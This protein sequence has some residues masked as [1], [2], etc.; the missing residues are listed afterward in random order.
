MFNRVIPFLILSLALIPRAESAQPKR[1]PEQRGTVILDELAKQPES[2]TAATRRRE[3]FDPERVIRPRANAGVKLNLPPEAPVPGPAPMAAAPAYTGFMGLPDDLSAIPPDTNGAVG[4]NHVVTMLNTQVLIQ[5]RDGTYRANYPINLGGRG[6]FWSRVTTAS[7]VYDPN[8][9]YDAANDRWIASAA[10]NSNTSS[11]ALLVGVS[12]TGDPGG[13]WNMYKINV[14]TSSPGNWGDYPVLGFNGN[15][16][17]VSLNLFNIDSNTNTCCNYVNTTLYV[18]NK[19]DLYSAGQGGYVTFSDENGELIPA[20]DFDKQPNTLYFVRAF[21]ADAGGLNGSGSIEIS[22]LQ[23]PVGSETFAGGNVGEIP[24]ADPW[25]DSGANGADFL[26]QLGTPNKID[27]GDSRVQNCVLRGGTIWC[28]HTI[29]LPYSSRKGP[30]RSSVQWFQ[31]DPAKLQVLQRG[32]IDD[33]SGTY[34]YAYPTIAV[35]ANNDVLVGYNRFSAQDYP[36]AE[37]SYRL[38]TDPPSTLEPDVL[39]AKGQ[40]SYVAPGFQT[41]NNRWGDF[42]RTWTDPVDDLTFWTI[43]EYAVTP[44]HGTTGQFGTWWAEVTAPSVVQ[45]TPP[46][47]TAQGVGNAASYQGGGVSPGELVTIFGSNLGPAAL[48]QPLVSA[49]GA[50]GTV[51]GGTSVYFDGTPA[52][53]IYASANQLAAIAPFSIQDRSQTVVQVS[54]LGN[55]SASVILPV[56]ATQPGIFTQNA[57]GQGQGDIL[58]A[59]SSVNTASNPAARGTAISIYATG[60]GVI[61]GALEGTLASPPYIQ[62]PATQAVSVLVGGLPAA[63]T[64]AGE[65]PGIVV[66]VLQINAVL[67][68]GVTPGNSVP[69]TV[70]VGGVTSKSG[71]TVA[72]K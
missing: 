33:P 29:F 37:F 11:S 45:A 5:S 31:V 50:V 2:H 15:W 6:G 3:V 59:D 20:A 21:A 60:G 55:T 72:V 42:S 61:P 65:A 57:S 34:F 36:S 12:Q 54:Y 53:M 67:P 35:N 1:I 43:Q 40:S 22:K 63:V 69:V 49:A 44:V 58:N 48:Q 30:T 16:I 71:V 56:V 52:T 68:A 51:A 25:A 27:A 38:A 23:G 10:V 32:R 28:A 39:F 41:T 19:A 62:I 18:F 47:M 64:Y 46:S 66:G 9:R 24:I 8:L 70:T 17:V 14:A 26:P 13:A 4:P 7:D